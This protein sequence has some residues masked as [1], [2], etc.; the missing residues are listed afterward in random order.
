MPGTGIASDA[1]PGI[2]KPAGRERQRRPLVEVVDGRQRLVEVV[3]RGGPGAV[4]Q[5]GAQ[6]A[7]EAVV[8][9]HARPPSGQLP[10]RSGVR[11][12]RRA[13]R[14]PRAGEPRLRGAL[15]DADGA[16][17]LAERQAV[18]VVEDDE[19]PL[20]RVEPAECPLQR[21]AVG[22]ARRRVGRRGVVDVDEDDLDRAPPDATELVHAG[23]DEE[24]PQPRVEPVRVAEPGQ[25]APRAGERL[26]DGVLRPLGVARDEAG[27]GVEAR[28]RA[29]GKAR[30]RLAV[31]S[32]CPHHQVPVHQSRHAWRGRSTASTP[33]GGRRGAAVPESV[34]IRRA[35]R[36]PAR[37]TGRSG[38]RPPRAARTTWRSTSARGPRRTARTRCPGRPRPAPRAAGAR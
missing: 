24:P 29:G 36:G 35:R 32:P 6:L 25:V 19:R 8:R 16:R 1:H 12:E 3:R 27:H 7:V 28:E 30:E 26:L 5:P 20:L 4:L 23:V 18:V 15:R 9:R 31:P 34:G 13:Q 21:V 2:R 33:Y 10:P 11:V 17:R 37:R 14:V 38:A 22:E